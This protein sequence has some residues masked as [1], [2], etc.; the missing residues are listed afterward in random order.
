MSSIPAQAA[1][2]DPPDPGLFGP[3]SIVWRVHGDPA[4]VIG[5]LRALLYQALNPRTMAAMDQHSDYRDEPWERFNRT[6]EYV[7]ATTFG[8]TETAEE[9]GRRVREIHERISGIDPVTGRAYRADDPE[10]LL[11][12][13]AAEIDSFLSAYQAYARP[14]NEKQA[15]RYVDEMRRA[16]ALV[17]LDLEDMPRSVGDLGE[18]LDG[19]TELAVTPAVR[20]AA[21]FVFSPPMPLV[22]RPLWQIPVTAAV[23]IL[24][25]KLRAL[26]GLSYPSVANAL[27]RPAVFTLLRTLNVVSP[28]SP[29]RREAFARLGL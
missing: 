29:Y 24:P 16:G 15:D 14:L 25:N 13:H 20:E 19:V 8:T 1:P 9:Y 18:Y 7:A 23:A 6:G 10:L 3:D 17:G 22:L 4:M 5:G 26:Y 2:L 21:H 28:G 27:V 11:W 12:I